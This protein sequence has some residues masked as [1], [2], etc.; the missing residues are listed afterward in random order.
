MHR[1]V[2]F[3]GAS[4]CLERCISVRVYMGLCIQR[5][6]YNDRWLL[7]FILKFRLIGYKLI[8]YIYFFPI[9]SLMWDFKLSHMYST[10][11]LPRM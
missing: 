5:L 1:E 8:L 7:F 11:L 10:N 3:L 4:L 9:S 6:A 2:L